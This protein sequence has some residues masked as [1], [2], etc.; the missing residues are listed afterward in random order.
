M[1][2]VDPRPGT[3][4]FGRHCRV[5]RNGGEGRPDIPSNITA[6]LRWRDGCRGQARARQTGGL[7]GRSILPRPLD[8][9]RLVAVVPPGLQYAPRVTRFYRRPAELV[10]IGDPV[11][12]FVP[13]RDPVAPGADQPI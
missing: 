11:R 3:L 13:V 5:S 12:G 8:L 4:S 7:S 10:P 2:F 6:R 1:S 9:R